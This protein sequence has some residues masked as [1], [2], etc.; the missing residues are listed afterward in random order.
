MKKIKEAI[1]NADPRM[2]GL[3]V[4]MI[5]YIGI[6]ATTLNAGATN[7]IDNYVETIDVKVQDGNQDQKDY[8]IRQASVSSVLDDLKISVNPQDILNLYQN[9]ICLFDYL[10]ISS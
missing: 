8:L 9:Y 3:L 2:K 10:F 4:V 1:I 5:A 7:Q 6:V